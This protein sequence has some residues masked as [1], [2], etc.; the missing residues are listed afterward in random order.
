[1]MDRNSQSYDF[2]VVGGG[3]AGCV[4]AGRLS[5]SGRYR[6]LLLEA[7]GPDSYPWIHIPMGYAKLYANPRV[8][9]CFSSEPEPELNNRRLFQP[10][11]KVLGGTGSINGMIYMRGQPEDFDGW[12]QLGCEGWGYRE[13]LPYF[14][15][16]EHQERGANEFHG[17]GG[18]LWVSDL[19]S[20][21][22]LADAFIAAAKQLGSPRN[23]DFNGASQEGAGYVQVTTRNGRRWSTAAGYLKL[24]NVKSALDVVTRALVRRILIENGRAVGVEYETPGGVRAAKSRAEVILAAGAFNSPQILQLSGI[25]PGDL[26]RRTGVPVLHDLRAV[27]ENLMDHCGVGVEY[28]CTKAITVNDIANNF[29][30]RMEVMARYLLFRSG[31][32]ASNG[33]FANTFVR[34]D[35]KQTRPD[36]MI[37]LMA[38]CT[39]EDLSPRPFSGF[40]ILAEHIRPDS[41]GSVRLR[42]PKPGDAPE[43]RFNFFVSDYDRRALINGLKMIRRLADAPALAAYVAEEINPG[44]SCKTDDQ[45]V[46]HCRKF[47]LSLLHAAG[48]CRMGNGDD[49]VVDPRLRVRGVQGVRVIDASVMP[50]IVSGNTNAATIMIAEKGVAMLLEDAKVR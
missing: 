35:E 29:L 36:L 20:K 22:A 23:D 43:I 10:R 6:T 16:A 8:N 27:G 7:G 47:A 49:A 2:I 38:W 30:L 32:M 37:T 13:V 1:M 26:L 4:V 50:T 48:T 5:E 40:T 45:F 46:A 15:N 41:R 33:N 44:P 39:G 21:H 11:G 3:S 9:W 28:R 24:P 25:G 18:P 34:S 17:T 12:R 14:K 19:P 42:S 31:P